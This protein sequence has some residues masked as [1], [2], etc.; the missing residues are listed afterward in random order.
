MPAL[1]AVSAK[2]WIVAT[3]AL[4]TL[5]CRG[6][7]VAAPGAPRPPEISAARAAGTPSVT[8]T[9]PSYA[10]QGTIALDVHIFGSGFDPSSRASWQKNGQVYEKIV[11]NSTSYVSATELVANISIASDAAVDSYDVAVTAAGGKPGIGTEMFTVTLAVSIDEPIGRAVNDAGQIVGQSST[12]GAS[13]WDPIEG[14]V[15]LDAGGVVWDI[16]RGGTY[17]GG[18][19]AA[20]HP[21]VWTSTG[22]PAGPWVPTPLPSLG[23]GGAVRGITSDAAGVAVMM[24]GNS[25]S[26]GGTKNPIVWTRTAAGWEYRIFS[27][28]AGIVSGAWGQAINPRG[29]VAGMDG[30]GCCNAVFWDSLGAPTR[31]APIT[32]GATAAAYSIDDAGTVI[33]GQS[34]GVAVMWTR[35]LVNGAYGPWSAAKALEA[36]RSVC[37]RGASIAYAVNGAGTVAVGSSCGAPVAWILGNG[38]VV[39]RRLLVGLG[40]PNNGVANGI[41][42]LPNPIITGEAN[43]GGVYWRT[44]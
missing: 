18:R 17:I 28:P 10:R 19:N 26:D 9:S 16:D 20:G 7:D 38:V 35:T 12:D 40:P 33:V 22:G 14:Y 37:K 11:V 39:E 31:L 42:D 6:T 44:F 13:L 3:A 25:F 8:S 23:Q 2:T 30:S 5:S 1:R 29:M 43:N 36:T 41:N 15:L 34:D 24:V 27:V 21:V 32:A 4:L